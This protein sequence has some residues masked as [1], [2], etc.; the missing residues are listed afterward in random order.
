MASITLAE[1]ERVLQAAKAKALQ[2]GVRVGITVVDSRGDPVIALK[3]DGANHFTFDA[4][5]GKAH[6]SAVFGVPSGETAAR[7]DSP[8]FR[9][10]VMMEG[11]RLIFSIGA[12]PLK[13]GSEVIG[14]IGVGGATGEQDEEI[15]RAGAAVL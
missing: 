6:V 14:A 10:L 5:R 1:A 8:V 4:S 13:Q 12:V 15:A 3:T 11:G 7:A 2:I 9:S